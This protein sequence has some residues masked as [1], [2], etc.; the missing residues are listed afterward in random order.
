M[1]EEN[2]F[3]SHP[4]VI[5]Y[6]LKHEKQGQGQ[7]QEEPHSGECVECG[8]YCTI[9]TANGYCEGCVMQ[10]VLDARRT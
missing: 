1:T 10:A 4:E 2:F 8:R 3:T 5:Q 7:G 6:I 9:I